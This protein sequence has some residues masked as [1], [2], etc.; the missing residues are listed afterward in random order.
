MWI[1][2]GAFA[3]VYIVFAKVDGENSPA[4]RRRTIPA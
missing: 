2:N 1:S 3:D 4:H